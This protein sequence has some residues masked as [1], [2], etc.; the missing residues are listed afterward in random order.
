M[1]MEEPK[2]ILNSIV[3]N[4]TQEGNTN[5]STVGTHDDEE[6]SITV[7]AA[8]GSIDTDGGFLIIRTSTGWSINDAKEFYELLKLTEN[9]VTISDS[10]ET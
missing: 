1:D 10:L 6:L 9:G 4:F 3:Y 7:E 2:P 8:L 5:G